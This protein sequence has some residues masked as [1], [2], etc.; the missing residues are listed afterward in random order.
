MQPKSPRIASNPANKAWLR[1]RADESKLVLAVCTG[2]FILGEAGLLDDLPAATTFASEIDNLAKRYPLLKSIVRN[3]RV[4]DTGKIITTG[5]LSA[6]MDGAL[7]VIDRWMGRND[8]KDVARG[9]EY[10]WAPDRKGSFGEL[11]ANRMPS[12]WHEMV[13]SDIP[14]DRYYDQ[15]DT[16]QWET[17]AHVGMV[18]NPDAFLDYSNGHLQSEDWAL[19]RK[20][21]LTRIYR[22]KFDGKNWYMTVALSQSK[23]AQAAREYGL[24][25]K[26]RLAK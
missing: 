4:V 22:R 17:R 20:G 26:V 19:M 10:D 13:P 18:A 16:K 6:G 24:S 5:G 21:S 15:G 1:K 12:M 7:H 23:S 14:F 9:L 11:A 3:R 2:A 8:A 25:V